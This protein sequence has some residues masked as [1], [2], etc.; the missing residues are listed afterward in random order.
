MTTTNTSTLIPEEN[1]SHDDDLN[2]A[3]R[4][5]VRTYVLWHD[6]TKAVQHF[7]VSCHTLWGCLE[8]G[9]LGTSLPRAVIDGRWVQ[10]PPPAGA[11]ARLPP[12][13]ATATRARTT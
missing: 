13:S 4:D 8:R 3:I 10:G 12:A 6:Q 7:G 11:A 2:D 1:E 9:R 5:Y